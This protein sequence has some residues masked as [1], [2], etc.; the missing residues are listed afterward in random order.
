MNLIS[1]FKKFENR[2]QPVISLTKCR[3]EFISSHYDIAYF[4]VERS[5]IQKRFDDDFVNK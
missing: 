5:L 4:F 3:F 2:Y 1:E